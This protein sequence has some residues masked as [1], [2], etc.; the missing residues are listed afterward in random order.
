VRRVVL[1]ANVLVS[2]VVSQS[3]PAARILELVSEG[4]LELVLSPLLLE[5]LT[6]VLRREKFQRYVSEEEVGSFVAFV[7]HK[8][9]VVDDAEQA[10][11]VRSPDPDD[12]YLI[13]LA[14]SERC[15][16]VSGDRHLLALAG[17]LPIYS[18]RDFLSLLEP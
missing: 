5:E 1:D 13:A 8:A 9:M 3:G 14:E 6:G 2:A 18:P 12:D 16:L 11:Q 4:A 7:A 17:D 15:A 10:P